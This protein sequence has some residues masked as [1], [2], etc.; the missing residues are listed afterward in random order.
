MDVLLSIATGLA[1]RLFLNSLDDSLGRLGPVLVGL[2]EGAVVHHLS[3]SSLLDHYLAY[4]L[5]V[6]VDF[7]F[8]YNLLLKL[9]TPQGHAASTTGEAPTRSQ[10]TSVTMSRPLWLYLLL[11]AQAVR[12]RPQV[13]FL[14]GNP[15]PS[16]LTLTTLPE[17]LLQNTYPFPRHPMSS[18][19]SLLLRSTPA[20]KREHDVPSSGP[21]PAPIKQVTSPHTRPP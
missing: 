5:R 16:W 12:L 9:S 10:L 18:I 20:A 2:W 14:K 15:N 3:T 13:Y 21:F 1:L 19:A 4:A 17:L 11:S 7:Y 8:T 6:A